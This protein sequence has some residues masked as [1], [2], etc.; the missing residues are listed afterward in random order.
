MHEID[1]VNEGIVKWESQST[2][3]FNFEVWTQFSTNSFLSLTKL[4][5]NGG[6]LWTMRRKERL[7]KGYA[8]S[9]ACHFAY[10]YHAFSL[11]PLRDL[12]ANNTNFRPSRKYKPL[13]FSSI[14]SS[15]RAS[16]GTFVSEVCPLHNGIV[17]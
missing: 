14:N 11:T 3:D 8:F 2:K 4:K 1:F 17:I 13:L 16:Y 6:G 9:M 7:K 12:S 15:S 5:E 10:Y